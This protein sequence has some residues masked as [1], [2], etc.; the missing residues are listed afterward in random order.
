MFVLL[1]L[2]L[3]YY[4]VLHFT[5]HILGEDW[6]QYKKFVDS[7][8]HVLKPFAAQM[9]VYKCVITDVDLPE[10]VVLRIL[11]FFNVLKFRK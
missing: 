1:N 6:L 7:S 2:L 10:L 3:I 8:V 9:K 11:L 5:L 4:I